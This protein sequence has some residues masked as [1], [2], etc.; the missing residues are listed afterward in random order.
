M[1]AVI[2]IRNK[3]KEMIQAEG[4]LKFVA[5]LVQSNLKWHTHI[6]KVASSIAIE[7]DLLSSISRK[8]LFWIFFAHVR[9]YGTILLENSSYT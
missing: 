9:A 5:I 3:I 7:L 4:R 1:F 2:L 6:D 8:Y